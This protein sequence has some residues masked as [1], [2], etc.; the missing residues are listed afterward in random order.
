MKKD[1]VPPSKNMVEAWRYMKKTEKKSYRE[2]AEE[3][4]YSI[5]TVRNYIKE[6]GKEERIDHEADMRVGWCC[7]VCG[8]YFK[9]PHG[10]NVICHSCIKHLTLKRERIMYHEATEDE[11]EV[12]LSGKG[13]RQNYRRKAS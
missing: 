10:Y 9:K 11:I 4:N 1:F 6:N 13:D 2:I 7:S 5:G 12:E 3:Y 8:I